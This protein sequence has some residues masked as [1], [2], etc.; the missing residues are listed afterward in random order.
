MSQSE[1]EKQK[2]INEYERLVLKRQAALQ[3]Q[4]RLKQKI[5]I[6]DK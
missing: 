1:M 6:K 4:S 5:S 3:H 2:A